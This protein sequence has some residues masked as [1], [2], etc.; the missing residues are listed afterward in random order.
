MQNKRG[1]FSTLFGNPWF[2]SSSSSFS[3]LSPGHSNSI[4]G[5]LWGHTQ[6]PLKHK[7]EKA[8]EFGKKIEPM[9]YTKY[10][11]HE[12]WN[13]NWHF[14]DFFSFIFLARNLIVM[15]SY[16]PRHCWNAQSF[17]QIVSRS[18]PGWETQKRSPLSE[19]AGCFSAWETL[20][21]FLVVVLYF[22]QNL[23]C[24]LK[25]RRDPSTDTCRQ[26]ACQENGVML[27][28]DLNR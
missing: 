18:L 6:Y 15:P 7:R 23:L 1:I 9:K 28:E 14:K 21:K 2:F 10:P 4:G 25:S 11:M 22:V 8:F 27:S 12:D 16:L 19:D 5:S 26:R 17:S 13:I 20:G 3:D 24:M